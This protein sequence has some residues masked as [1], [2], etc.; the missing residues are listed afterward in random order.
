MESLVTLELSGCFDI[1]KI[2][3]FV[4]NMGCL[5]ELKLDGTGIK[6]LPSSIEGLIGLTSLS[7]A[8]CDDLVCL[9]ST[10]CSLKSLES[11]NLSGC[12]NF[13]NLPKNLGNVKGLKRLDLRGTTIK[14]LPLSIERL[15]SLTSLNI[16]YCKHL[17]CLPN[18]TCGFKF[19]D[20]LDL[21]TC[22][23]F[24]NLPE[25]PW[26]IKDLGML[27]LS[28]TA[29]EEIHSSIGGLIGL[30]SLTLRSCNNLVCLQN[31]ICCLK[32][33]ERL[34]LSMSSKFENLPENLG[35]LKALKELDLSGT[36]IK[37][38]PSSIEG[39]TSLTLLTLR[40]CKNLVC[41]P[42]TICNLKLL[43]CLDLFCCSNFDNLP[44]NLGNV[45]GLKKLDLSGT[46]IKE[47]PSSFEHLTSLTSLVILD[48]NKLVSLPNTTCGF[49]FHG[50]L[51]LSTCPRFKNLPENPWIIED[52]ERLKL[53]ETAIEE[54]PSSI[55]HLKFLTILTLQDC[56]NLVCFP[57]TICSLKSLE[58]LDLSWCSKL[59]NL[60]KNLG[61]LKALKELDLSR[62]PIK[63][64]PSSIEG[65]TSLTLLTLRY[66]KNLVCLPSTICN[67]KSLE[68]LDLYWCSNFDNLPNNLGN[69]KGLKKLDLSRTAIKELP[70]S[71]EHLTNLTLLTLRYCTNLVRLS[72]TICSLK[73]LNP[74]DLFG[75]LKFD[76][77]PENIGNMEGLEVLNLC[78]TAIKEVPSSIVLLKNLKQLNIHGWKLSDFYS[79]PA[80]LES[81]TALQTSSI[82]LPT[83]PPRKR[84]LPSSLY[85]SLPT[86]PV[87][88]GLL[89]PTLSGLQSLTYLYLRDCDISSIPNDIGCLSSLECLNLSGNNFV[90]LPDS[91]S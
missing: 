30:T 75:C 31:T 14:E 77:L 90:S 37:E 82:F 49:K 26:I 66:C 43:E 45:K 48:C 46:A 70:S 73:L 72:S 42:S 91:M 36:T 84:L 39:L 78:W 44:N 53:S 63:E 22:L 8:Y 35:N 9:P 28:D 5:Q 71:I 34:D 12:S 65:L 69:V 76:N 27:D 68:C 74:L 41:L 17:V 2:P 6:E 33:L 38:F 83:S 11:L 51:D 32:S 81:M 62:T 86:S 88:M 60:P 19:H 7:L 56:K 13:D 23:R 21:S 40:Y 29:I 87:P 64:F 47:L 57:S 54:L 55:E 79:Q 80:S 50:A 25:N 10:I 1:E 59:D 58:H 85:F 52:L 18:T 20:A 15:T 67:L 16:R 3:K 89:L 24:K 61:N 4:G